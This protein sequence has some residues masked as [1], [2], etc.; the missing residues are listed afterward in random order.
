[1][2]SR[3]LFLLASLIGCFLSAAQAQDNLATGT[4]AARINVTDGVRALE[5][6][7]AI[8]LRRH[9]FS[10]GQ[11]CTDDPRAGFVTCDLMNHAAEFETPA[12]KT[13]DQLWYEGGGAEREKL[14]DQ[15]ANEA[16]DAFVEEVIRAQNKH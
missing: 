7:R 8:C 1:M 4:S 16:D 15:K 11:R 9:W 6:A 13:I 14:R 12:C 5:Q 3:T 2:T 10:G